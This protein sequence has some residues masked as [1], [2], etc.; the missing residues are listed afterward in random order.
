MFERAFQHWIQRPRSSTHRQST[1]RQLLDR[2]A[3]L[4]MFLFAQPSVYF[5]T[6]EMTP[7]NHARKLIPTG[8]CML[9]V[10]DNNAQL[11][12]ISDIMIP[13]KLC[14]AFDDSEDELEGFQISIGSSSNIPQIV[15][16][17]ENF[18]EQ[19]APRT[20]TETGQSVYNTP[21]ASTQSFR[22][23]A[24]HQNYGN[25]HAMPTAEKSIVQGRYH[26]TSNHSYPSEL[27]AESVFPSRDS[28]D[29]PMTPDSLIPGFRYSGS[30]PRTILEVLNP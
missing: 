16:S 23:A 8:P 4:G 12:P 11:R 19:E 21:E 30:H 18:I 14:A 28:N 3:K 26:P 1:F 25:S 17:S 27:E 7:Q 2:A 9:R 5:F 29:Y 24:F 6:W 20:S 15:S 22:G 13:L 10:F